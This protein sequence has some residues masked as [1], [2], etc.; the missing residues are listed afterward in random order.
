[1]YRTVKRQTPCPNVGRTYHSNPASAGFFFDQEKHNGP[2]RSSYGQA[3][4]D[5]AHDGK[6]QAVSHMHPICPDLPTAPSLRPVALRLP[7]SQ[8]Q[9]IPGARGRRLIGSPG[10]A[11]RASSPRQSKRRLP[12][13]QGRPALRKSS[14]SY[15]LSYR[16]AMFFK[17][18]RRPHAWHGTARAAWPVRAPSQGIA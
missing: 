14:I 17:T 18:R 2:A 4:T 16:T 10:S 13:S 8:I 7:N 15:G 3:R 11:L 5:R 6:P 1:M 12:N 9:R